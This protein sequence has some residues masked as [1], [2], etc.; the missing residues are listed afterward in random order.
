MGELAELAE[1]EVGRGGACVGSSVNACMEERRD[2]RTELLTE[3]PRQEI[4]A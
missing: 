3:P 1:S 2:T 4:A